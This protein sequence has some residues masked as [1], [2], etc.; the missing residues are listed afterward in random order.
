MIWNKFMMQKKIIEQLSAVFIENDYLMMNAWKSATV[1][2]HLALAGHSYPLLCKPNLHPSVLLC[3]GCSFLVYKCSFKIFPSA[4]VYMWQTHC[5][6]FCS[7]L[8]KTPL[9]F[10]IDPPLEMLHLLYHMFSQGDQSTLYLSLFSMFQECEDILAWR[11]IHMLSFRNSHKGLQYTL[12]WLSLD[13]CLHGFPI[14]SYK[15]P[16]FACLIEISLSFLPLS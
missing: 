16:S 12:N 13:F 7:P 1:S 11:I 15:S 4:L 14:F 10:F 3:T 2:W 6:P 5:P 9:Y 8:L